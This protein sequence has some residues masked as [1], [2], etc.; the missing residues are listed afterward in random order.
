MTRAEYNTAV[1]LYADNLYRFILKNIQDVDKSKDIVQDTFFK[2]VEPPWGD[3]RGKSEIVS[4]F[5]RV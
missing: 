4:V 1:D 3:C 5:N 2:G